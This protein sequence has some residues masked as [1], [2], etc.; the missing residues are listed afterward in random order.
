[1]HLLLLTVPPL[2]GI[3]FLAFT[4]PPFYAIGASLAVFYS[5]LLTSVVLYRLSPFHPLARYPGPLP[6]K[7]TKFWMAR[8]GLNGDQHT[9]MKELH[10]LYGDVVRTGKQW[11]FLYSLNR[12]STCTSRPK[13]TVFQRPIYPQRNAGAVWSPQRTV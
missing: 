6:C 3:G 8:I 9:Y 4:L 1:M 7:L 13:R 11:L 5:T 12:N 10:D 2:A